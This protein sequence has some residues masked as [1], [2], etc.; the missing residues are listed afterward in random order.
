[1]KC[2]NLKIFWGLRPQT[3]AAAHSAALRTTSLAPAAAR[4]VALRATSLAPTALSEH[5]LGKNNGS[6]IFLAARYFR[7]HVQF[8]LFYSLVTGM[9]IL[10]RTKLNV[11][12]GQAQCSD[13]LN[14]FKRNAQRGHYQCSR[15]QTQCPE[16][17]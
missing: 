17:S 6:T 1:M 11:Q 4:S 9:R 3:P 2:K 16:G 14:A 12:R 15:G 10:R 8:K 7:I 5:K 13:G